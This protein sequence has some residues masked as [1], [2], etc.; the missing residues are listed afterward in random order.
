MQLSSCNYCG[1]NNV[2]GC[3]LTTYLCHAIFLR[4]CRGRT[5]KRP[6]CGRRHSA[7]KSGSALHQ[8]VQ[9]WRSYR[10]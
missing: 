4:S 6:R 2:S 10:N 8:G 3:M 5:G 9:K 7:W 1:L